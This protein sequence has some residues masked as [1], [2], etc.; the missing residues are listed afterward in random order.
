MC[1]SLDSLPFLLVMRTE[2]QKERA[3]ARVLLSIRVLSKTNLYILS[4]FYTFILLYRIFFIYR[5]IICYT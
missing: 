4:Y 1:V 3:R 2:K 5:D